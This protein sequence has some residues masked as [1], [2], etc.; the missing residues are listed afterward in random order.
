MC[1]AEGR[2]EF[3]PLK[4]RQDAASVEKAMPCRHWKQHREGIPFGGL[5]SSTT[6]RKLVERLENGKKAI[7]YPYP[8]R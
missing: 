5:I 2:R 7:T 6:C 1:K 3:Q 8:E 4:K